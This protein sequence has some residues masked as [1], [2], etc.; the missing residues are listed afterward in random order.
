MSER[1]IDLARKLRRW[2]DA[3]GME[4]ARGGNFE[5]NNTVLWA[6]LMRKGA[7]EIDALF[8]VARGVQQVMDDDPAPDVARHQ[9]PGAS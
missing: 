4:T 6:T 7:D 9:G 2:A 8:A 1:T 5:R 3:D